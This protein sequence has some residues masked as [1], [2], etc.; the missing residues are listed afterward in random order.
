M[1]KGGRTLSLPVTLDSVSLDA[2]PEL[3]SSQKED[4]PG[5][6]MLICC[7]LQ[8]PLFQRG[9]SVV[10]RSTGSGSCTAEL[11][12]FPLSVTVALNSQVSVEPGVM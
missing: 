6:P 10:C 1:F 9:G 7:F 4:Y 5:E 12:Q 11:Q 8:V 2:D 3:K